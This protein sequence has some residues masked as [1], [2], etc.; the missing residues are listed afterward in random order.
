MTAPLIE[1]RDSDDALLSGSYVIAD[2][3]SGTPTAAVVR[4]LWN[5]Y[6]VAG[7]DTAETVELYALARDAGGPAALYAEGH[8]FVDRFYFEVRIT[9]GLGG[10][11]V[12]TSSWLRVGAGLPV[13][14]PDIPAEQGLV[15]EVRVH[16]PGDAADLHALPQLQVRSQLSVAGAG[17]LPSGVLVGPGAIDQILTSSGVAVENPGGVDDSVQLGTTVYQVDEVSYVEVEQLVQLDDEDGDAAT[18]ASGEAYYGLVVWTA[19]G[20]AVRKGS[21]ATTPLTDDDEPALLPGDVPDCRV[22]REFDAL[23]EDADITDRRQIGGFDYLGASGLTATIGGGSAHVQRYEIR[24]RNSSP[25]TLLANDDNRV[26]LQ[27]DGTFGVNQSDTPTTVGAELIW[28]LTTDASTVTASKD[29]RSLKGRQVIPIAFHFSGPLSGQVVYA[30][31]PYGVTGRLL[32]IRPVSVSLLDAWGGTGSTVFDLEESDAGGAWSSYF[33]SAPTPDLR[34]TI[35][36]ADVSH[37]AAIPERIEVQPG[38]R[39][40]ASIPTVPSGGSDPEVA[41]MIALVHT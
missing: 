40:R 23:I 33:P 31:W 8:E 30:H 28:V 4:H 32:G 9:G 38:A 27:T 37:H 34:P 35:D 26:W 36:A 2:A 19:T 29:E 7:A 10:L 3:E 5:S 13:A 20:P 25:V 11:S 24:K 15:L 22:L 21:K 18:L 41:T 17:S 39:L 6:G 16:A 1:W 12:A 14:L